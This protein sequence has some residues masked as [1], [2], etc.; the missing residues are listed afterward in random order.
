MKDI[1]GWI[2]LCAVLASLI[3][4]KRSQ[5]LVGL[6]FL[7]LLRAH[8]SADRLLSKSD[9]SVP[10]VSAKAFASLVYSDQPIG[11][12]P[13]LFGSFLQISFLVLTLLLR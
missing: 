12:S 6:S 2:S 8:S 4:S 1:E 13:S 11:V 3:R 5:F 9:T 7:P 10:R